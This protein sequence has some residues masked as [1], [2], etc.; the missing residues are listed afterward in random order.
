[1]V[2]QYRKF[3][4]SN[5]NGNGRNIDKKDIKSGNC[6][7]IREKEEDPIGQIN[8]RGF[9]QNWMLQAQERNTWTTFENLIEFISSVSTKMLTQRLR[10]KNYKRLA[11]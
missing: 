6:D 1:M 10:L 7:Q 2:I 4:A 9:Q 11:N 5:G 8:L 3:G